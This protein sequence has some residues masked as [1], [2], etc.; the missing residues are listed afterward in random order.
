MD[1]SWCA[2]RVCTTHRYHGQCVYSAI[3]TVIS[4]TYT[5][6]THALCI[7]GFTHTCNTASWSTHDRVVWGS[8]MCLPLLHQTRAAPKIQHHP[9][10]PPPPPPHP[11]LPCAQVLNLG[12]QQANQQWPDTHRER[13]HFNNANLYE[14]HNVSGLDWAGCEICQL[15]S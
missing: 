14:V 5:T 13:A 2:C 10:S 8:K 1:Q 6:Y 4:H 12:G 7:C 3:R 15:L 11:G 9:T